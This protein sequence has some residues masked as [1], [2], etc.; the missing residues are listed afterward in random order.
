MKAAFSFP[1]GTEVIAMLKIF[2]R[3]VTK[4]MVLLK[5]VGIDVKKVGISRLLGFVDAANIKVLAEQFVRVGSAILYVDED[6]QLSW[7][8]LDTGSEQSGKD[9]FVYA[10]IPTSGETPVFKI[11]LNSSYPSGYDAEN[12]RKI[13]GF[14][15]NPDGDILQ[16][17]LWDR[18][19]IL[20]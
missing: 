6:T 17:S 20:N 1:H 14:H 4:K 8:D 13:G 2:P 12:S 10:C 16:Y 9:Y 7:A 18:L 3:S 11:S 15:N 5:A 19:E